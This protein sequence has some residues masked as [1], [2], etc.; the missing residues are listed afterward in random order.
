[1]YQCL[2]QSIRHLHKQKS[3]CTQV[4]FIFQTQLPVTRLH[5]GHLS[6]SSVLDSSE[7]FEESTSSSRSSPLTSSTELLGTFLHEKH[8]HPRSTWHEFLTHPTSIKSSFC[9]TFCTFFLNKYYMGVC[10][11]NYTQWNLDYPDI[12]YLD[13]R[14][15]RMEMIEIMGGASNFMHMNRLHVNKIESRIEDRNQLYSITVE[16]SDPRLSYYAQD[17]SGV[18]TYPDTF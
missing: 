5:L 18:F 2:F 7:W 4:S 6:S 14:L 15:S 12:D 9:C 1:M 10:L 17:I 8:T 13:S 3:I 11:V 16:L